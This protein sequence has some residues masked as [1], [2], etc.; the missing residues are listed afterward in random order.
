MSTSNIKIL[1]L[2]IRSLSILVA[3][4]IMSEFVS[5][6][7]WVLY[8]PSS[9]VSKIAMLASSSKALAI[10]WLLSASAILPFVIMQAF[11]PVC[12][13]RRVI[14]KMAN[15]GMIGGAAIWVLLAFVGRN[16][17][18]NFAIWNFIINALKA[19]AMVAIMATS[20]NNDQDE[21]DK[22]KKKEAL[23]EILRGST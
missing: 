17:D 5:P 6:A 1:Y 7:L 8:E 16:L 3:F 19:M 14:M 2:I 21:Q 22:A 13:Y 10:L 12:R 15:F 9:V 23:R 18:Y 4:Q 11:F 20:L